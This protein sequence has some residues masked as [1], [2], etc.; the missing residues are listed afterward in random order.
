VRYQRSALIATNAVLS[1][2][3]VASSTH[4]PAAIMFNRSL[5]TKNKSP[6]RPLHDQRLT[7][8]SLRKPPLPGAMYEPYKRME[9]LGEVRRR[10]R[11]YLNRQDVKIA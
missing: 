7:P 4:F 9:S 6:E 5:P 2:M 11:A 8:N 3:A 10:A 1:E